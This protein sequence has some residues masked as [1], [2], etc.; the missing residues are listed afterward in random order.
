MMGLVFLAPLVSV[1]V[2]SLLI[3]QWN[4]GDPAW[5]PYLGAGYGLL[6]MLA[7]ALTIR[8]L[9]REN[10]AVRP[11]RVMN[12]ACPWLPGTSAALYGA[13]AAAFFRAHGWRV[14]S[15]AP[16]APGRVEVVIRKDRWTVALLVLAPGGARL[17]ADDL[18]RLEAVRREAG[19]GRKAVVSAGDGGVRPAGLLDPVSLTTLRFEDLPRLEDALGLWS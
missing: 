9:M 19:A 18:G 4:N 7:A 15:A 6:G 12:E 5:H 17:S 11:S 8:H 3:Y 10:A 14:A 2:I 1:F 16:G 13:Q